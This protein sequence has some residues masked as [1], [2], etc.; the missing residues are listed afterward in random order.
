VNNWQRYTALCLTDGLHRHSRGGSIGQ[1]IAGC[2]HCHAC[3]LAG[4]AQRR[5]A[6]LRGRQARPQRRQLVAGI[7]GWRAGFWLLQRV[8]LYDERGNL[9]VKRAPLFHG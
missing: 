2:Q 1:R 8:D 7:L 9:T 6:F 4:R 5:A 3:G